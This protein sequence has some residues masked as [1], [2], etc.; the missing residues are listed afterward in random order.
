MAKSKYYYCIVHK[1][2]GAFVMNYSSTEIKPCRLPIYLDRKTAR[3][4]LKNDYD[5][6]KHTIQ[7]IKRDAL[8]KLVL[9]ST[10]A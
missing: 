5:R 8:E 2:N 4:W 3:Q 10:K 7:R 1:D 6:A 9:N